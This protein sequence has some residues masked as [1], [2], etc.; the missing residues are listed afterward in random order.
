MKAILDFIV[1]DKR[2]ILTYAAGGIVATILNLT[3]IYLA[4]MVMTYGAAVLVGAVVATIVSFLNAKYFVFGRRKSG[5]QV[6]EIIK[7][8]CVHCT[9]IVL[10]WCVSVGLAEFLAF[11]GMHGYIEAISSLVGVSTFTVT[12]FLGHRFITFASTS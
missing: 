10:Y 8:L 4:R 7:F 1:R 12:G 9:A 2:Q 6:T 11:R 3:A 5:R